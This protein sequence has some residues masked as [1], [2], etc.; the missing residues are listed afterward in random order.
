MSQNNEKCGKCQDDDFELMELLK[1]NHTGIF[2]HYHLPRLT[3]LSLAF[4]PSPGY[5]GEAIKVVICMVLHDGQIII[6][7]IRTTATRE[8]FVLAYTLFP[9]LL[10][11][12][13]L[14]IT[15]E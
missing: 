1:N 2:K 14:S 10:F 15:D 6:L 7:T 11:R 13:P 5:L 12:E 9:F 3:M 4:G 8:Y